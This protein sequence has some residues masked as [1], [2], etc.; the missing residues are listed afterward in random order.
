MVK[1]VSW[2]RARTSGPQATKSAKQLDAVEELAALSSAL[3]AMDCIM[4]DDL[5]CANKILGSTSSKS[6]L[7][8]LAKG[9]LS[10]IE[11]TLGFEADKIRE[12][13]EQLR[14]AEAAALR[15]RLRAQKTQHQSSSFAPGTEYYLAVA[16]AHLMGAVVLFLSE[17][18]IASVKSFYK[19]RRAYQILADIYNSNLDE[20]SPVQ[21]LPEIAVEKS[22]LAETADDDNEPVTDVIGVDQSLETADLESAL[23]QVLEK[24]E[25]DISAMPE[26][27]LPPQPAHKFKPFGGKN[28]RNG[29]AATALADDYIQSGVN[30]CFGILQLVISMIPPAFGRVLSLIGFRGDRDTSIQMLWEA[31]S[32][33]NIHGALALLTLLL[34]YTGPA[35]ACDIT[36]SET[37]FPRDRLLS[38]LARTRKRY[39]TS[40]LWILQEARLRG[41]DGDL[42]RSLTILQTPMQIQMR[43]VQA[44]VEFEKAM[45]YLDLHEFEPAAETFVKLTNLNS[46]SHALYT[47]VAGV[48]YVELYRGASRAA[49][50]D[51]VKIAMYKK[52]AEEL[53]LS[54]PS[55]IGKRRITGRPMPVE[56]Y[57]QRK[58]EKWKSWMPPTSP[59]D[60]KN[61]SSTSVNNASSGVQP[62]IVDY[63]GTSPANEIIYF[64]NGYKRMPRDALEKSLAEL[65]FH[66]AASPA[67]VTPINTPNKNSVYFQENAK[68]Y[69]HIADIDE[70]GVKFI[71]ESIVLRNLGYTEIGLKVLESEVMHIS[72]SM[73]KG[74]HREDWIPPCGMYEQAVFEWFVKGTDGAE[75]TL[76][77]LNKAAHYGH[78]YELN[79]RIGV[80]IQTA[81][82][83]LKSTSSARG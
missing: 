28:I 21:K 18:A 37:S 22:E 15:D 74:N 70:L 30:L 9:V 71:L 42:Q 63:I 38:V 12:A 72:R 39:P 8:A 2:I 31:T 35:Q 77:L 3:K 47:Y 36:L 43:Q 20:N 78:E 52:K 44:L 76:E 65:N 5:E 40:A 53:L 6:S 1:P 19:L 7:P 50:K 68:K 46:W 32:S 59:K 75:K 56:L 23:E 45:C 13:T 79:T 67:D 11:A 51:A 64:W 41:M 57:L 16:E 27:Q 29:N 58:V 66:Y 25:L 55:M 83:V 14:V 49:K 80:R 61:S 4:A 17:S 10:F 34:Y 73:L 69:P 82:E 60:S 62:S 24:D 81:V 48:C 26:T 33:D 54:A